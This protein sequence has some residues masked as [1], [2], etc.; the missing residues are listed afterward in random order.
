MVRDVTFLKHLLTNHK[1]LVQPA[2]QSTVHFSKEGDSTG[3]KFWG[4]EVMQQCKI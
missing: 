4:R 1:I 2:N 3:T